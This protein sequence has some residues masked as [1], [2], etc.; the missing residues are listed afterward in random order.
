MIT[1]V[2]SISKNIMT[3]SIHILSWLEKKQKTLHVLPSVMV[4][5]HELAFSTH[6]TFV[7]TWLFWSIE[8]TFRTDD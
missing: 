8:F 2:L 7:L 1:S 3:I 5:Y 4:S 6:T